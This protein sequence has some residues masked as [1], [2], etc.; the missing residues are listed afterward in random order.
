MQIEIHDRSASRAYSWIAYRRWTAALPISPLARVCLSVLWDRA[1]TQPRDL[2]KISP[3]NPPIV[4][5]SQRVIGAWAQTT[6]RAIRR[7]V[8]SLEEAGLIAVGRDCEPYSYTLAVPVVRTGT[9]LKVQTDNPQSMF[10]DDELSPATPDKLSGVETPLSGSLEEQTPSQWGDKLLPPTE[11]QMSPSSGDK[12]SP[13]PGDISSPHKEMHKQNPE[14]SSPAPSEREI[15]TKSGDGK[16]PKK[17]VVTA[18]QRRLSF[19]LAKQICEK[20]D[21][22]QI[23]L[24][25][26]FAA[27][28]IQKLAR[29]SHCIDRI[30]REAVAACSATHASI[31]DGLAKDRQNYWAKVLEEKMK[32]GL[33]VEERTK[34]SIA[35][36]RE[37]ALNMA[38]SIGRGSRV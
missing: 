17:R 7:I 27:T 38:S 9:I 11:D 4:R 16:L 21:A 23:N 28:V 19:A 34:K 37:I 20:Y 2:E 31:K 30:L 10:R 1:L 33:S 24:D 35:R 14:R 36:R 3:D 29:D 32:D 6:P 25:Y 13:P 26:R 8:A 5:V 12:M 22:T 18:A 15:S